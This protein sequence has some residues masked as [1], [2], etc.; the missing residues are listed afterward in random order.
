MGAVQRHLPRS[1]I[2]DLF[3]QRSF[4]LINRF[5]VDRNYNGWLDKHNLS[6]LQ[7]FNAFCELCSEAFTQCVQKIAKKGHTVCKW[8]YLLSSPVT[9]T[10]SVIQR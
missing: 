5:R 10:I 2:I 7:T 9:V 3:E 4:R 1:T 8:A 6:S